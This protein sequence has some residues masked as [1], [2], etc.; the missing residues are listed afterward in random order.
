M[1]KF[2]FQKRFN[3]IYAIFLIGVPVL[4]A[5]I[6]KYFFYTNFWIVFSIALFSLIV[7]GIIFSRE[8][9]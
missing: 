4:V 8:E 6:A 9:F 7:N 2:S 3:I 5:S 1:S